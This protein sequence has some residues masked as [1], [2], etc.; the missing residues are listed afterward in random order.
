MLRGAAMLRGARNVRSRSS[1]LSTTSFASI[2]LPLPAPRESLPKS[3]PLPRR[4]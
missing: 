1:R 2:G 4:R 3:A